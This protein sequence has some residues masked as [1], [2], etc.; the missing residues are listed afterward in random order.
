MSREPESRCQLKE[1]IALHHDS[2]GRN[3]IPH[4]RVAVSN[5]H[6]ICLTKSCSR[7][8]IGLRASLLVFSKTQINCSPM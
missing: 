8:L 6:C 4:M 2:G 3:A 1:A 5:E 7:R